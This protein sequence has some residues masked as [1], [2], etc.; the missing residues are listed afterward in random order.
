M[1]GGNRHEEHRKPLEG[2]GRSGG[3]M[4][5]AGN[6]PSHEGSPGMLFDLRDSP[7]KGIFAEGTGGPKALH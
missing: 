5:L 4:F 6:H 3:G 2:Q 7:K 1:G